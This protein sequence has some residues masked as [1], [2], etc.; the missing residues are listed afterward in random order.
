MCYQARDAG[1]YELQAKRHL[2]DAENHAKE[3]QQRPKL[4]NDDV[5]GKHG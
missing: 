3:H 4:A 2:G 1:E 5:R